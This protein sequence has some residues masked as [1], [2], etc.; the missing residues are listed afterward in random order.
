MNA[1]HKELSEQVHKYC[2]DKIW[3]LMEEDDE[4][5]IF[6]P[7]LFHGLGELGLCGIPIPSQYG[8]AELKYH[9]LC[10]VL[11]IIA[12]YS[13]PYAVTVSVSTMVQGI[14]L[15]FGSEKQK[16]KY[17]PE[18]AEG[19]AIASFA[20]S[21]S[22]AGSD[23]AS[24]KTTAKKT[25]G[26]YIL[27]GS[28][29]WISSAGYSKTYVVMARTGAEG[30]KGISAFIVEDG[31][32]GFS[33]GKREKKMGWRTSATCEILF[34]NCFVPEENLI[35]I[36]GQGFKIALS[37]LN[38][39]RITIAAISIGLAEKA[40]DVATRYALE[41]EQ[42]GKAI[43]SFQGLQFMIAENATEIEAARSLMEKAC[44]NYDN[45]NINIKIA[46]MAKLKATDVAMKATTDAVQILGGVGYTKEYPVE[47]FMRDAKVL[48]IVEGTNQIQKVIIAR[49][50]K[51]ERT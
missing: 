39:G 50:M 11:S 45:N 1:F 28:K 31:M 9:D 16:A 7:E 20:F 49:E 18:L 26:G 32:E 3:P 22:H 2:S 37:G 8:G 6:R 15:E 12:G 23:A 43:Y 44:E 42:F 29:M 30:S 17:L 14:L 41:R 35:G 10:I 40:I 34:E 25:K 36:E 24:M 13:V 38:K 46:A 27:N 4:K 47:R 48:Q 33:I 19:K 51:N 5:E 21:E